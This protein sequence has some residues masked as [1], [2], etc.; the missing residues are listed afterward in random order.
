M[1]ERRL[2]IETEVRE[3]IK[4]INAGKTLKGFDRDTQTYF[5]CYKMHGQYYFGTYTEGVNCDYEM[6][7]L[8]CTDK[9]LCKYILD[10]CGLYPEFKI[11]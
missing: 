5:E 2:D 7:E 4:E 8:D 3:Y 10:N 1:I 9:T 11:E 6:Q